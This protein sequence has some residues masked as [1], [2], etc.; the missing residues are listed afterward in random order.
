M[1]NFQSI[2]IIPRLD[3]KNENVIKSINLEGL[4]VVGNPSDLAHKYYVQGA[5]EL[6]YVDVVASLYGRN[7]LTEVLKR[8]SNN[9]FIPLTVGGGI[10]CLKDINE[11]LLAGA[12]R[13]LINTQA[14]K[15]P[16]F[17]YEAAKEFGSS[18]IVVGV[19]TY[20]FDDNNYYALT[21]NGRQT[22]GVNIEEWVSE[23]YNLG[24]GEISVTSISNE[25][26]GD[27]YDSELLNRIN[28]LLPIP[29]IFHGGGGNKTHI[30]AVLTNSN[31]PNALA[32]SS[33]F[34]YDIIKNHFNSDKM[35]SYS[36]NKIQS[37]GVNE[38]KIFLN[39]K[40]I[41]VRT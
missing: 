13:V 15:T 28:K 34:H 16:N 29:I 3:V 25:G 30:E 12:D 26:V 18:T 5:D 4:R 40:G 1:S 17:I 7:S 38:L 33:L 14:I 36:P 9:I 27:G 8:T 37:I 24:A 20:K 21:D 32:I 22:T 41:K 19:E 31:A 23:I 6:L 2:R 35:K 39:S 11:L 10:R